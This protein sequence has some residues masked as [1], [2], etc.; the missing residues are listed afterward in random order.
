[1]AISRIYGA[2]ATATNGGSASVTISG[3][4]VQE[5]DLVIATTAIAEIT[6]TDYTMAMTSTGYTLL[7]GTD[8]HAAD[9]DSTDLAIF[10]KF[11]GA[12]PDSTVTMTGQGGGTA[13]CG[14]AV[15]I[16]RG[17]DPT[18]PFD[19]A[20]TTN[21]QSNTLLPDPPSITHNNP[22]GVVTVIGVASSSGRGA[23][24]TYTFPTGYTTNA[25]QAAANDSADVIV[26]CA[27]NTSPSNPED[28]GALTVNLGNSTSYSCA[29]VT[30]ALR[31]EATDANYSATVTEITAV[32]V[33]QDITATYDAILNAGVSEISLAL[34]PQDV[35]AS[36]DL[37][38]TADVVE[39]SM[40]LA[41][42]DITATYD[43]IYS[44]LVTEVA[45]ALSP[46][47]V[48]GT[49]DN[50]WSAS[51]ST[52]DTVMSVQAVSP[53]WSNY[54]PKK[55]YIDSDGEVYWVISQSIGLV[56]KI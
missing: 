24:L 4:G 42:Q 55:Y 34:T 7:S 22:S 48:T 38:S 5:G 50:G 49:Y 8:L 28:P 46:Q 1:M 33:P 27:Y 40:T 16:F 29:S 32:V 56:E 26:G 25:V 30:M 6:G 44:A 15:Q 20:A 12:T 21:T 31:P 36:S 35:A 14:I 53:Q 23:S 52:V 43:A 51:V 3:Q 2:A 41:P 17:V 37:S 39:V 18:T 54:A 47:A 9:T 45:L 10:Y 19:V 13:S 11:M